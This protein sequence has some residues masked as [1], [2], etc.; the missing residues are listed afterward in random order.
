[1]PPICP[2]LTVGPHCFCLSSDIHSDDEDADA[3]AEDA[4]DVDAFYADD[5]DDDLCHT[6]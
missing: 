2:N 5:A 1:M 6:F 3:V 4:E